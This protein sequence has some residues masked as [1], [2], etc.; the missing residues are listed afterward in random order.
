MFRKRRPVNVNATS[1][2]F[3]AGQR[4]MAGDEMALHALREAEREGAIEQLTLAIRS[5][6]MMLEGR[7]GAEANRVRERVR[8]LQPERRL[9]CLAQRRV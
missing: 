4:W 6:E 9:A 7:R 5:R 2:L 8:H 3:S 1:G